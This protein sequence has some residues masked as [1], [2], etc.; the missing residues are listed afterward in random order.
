[1]ILAVSN[2]NTSNSKLRAVNSKN[3]YMSRTNNYSQ[4][5]DT[6]IKSQNKSK[7]SFGNL[8]GAGWYGTQADRDALNYK[9]QLTPEQVKENM[10]KA[11]TRQ[12]G[13]LTSYSQLSEE[14]QHV[15][16]AFK[17]MISIKNEFGRVASSEFKEMAKVSPK[18]SKIPIVGI[19][20]QITSIFSG[21]FGD[22]LYE[23]YD[24]LSDDMIEIIGRYWNN[25]VNP[26]CSDYWS[27][28]NSMLENL[29]GI[30]SGLKSRLDASIRKGHSQIS[31]NNEA[32][33]KSI[34]ALQAK[35]HPTYNNICEKQAGKQFLRLCIKGVTL[36]IGGFGF[37]EILAGPLAD[38]LGD[39]ATGSIAEA[40]L[41]S[42]VDELVTQGLDS[43]GNT[44]KEISHGKS[45]K[46]LQLSEKSL[47]NV[48]RKIR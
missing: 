42:G 18:G 37:E 29:Y 27:A 17:S 36:G 33:R 28:S 11:R 7:I 19:V 44:A 41:N 8:H 38:L 30:D 35:L 45:S 5:A 16:Q 9:V 26:I 3:R 40:L 14:A 24:R 23:F 43:I 13:I 4:S 31:D 2:L 32:I 25:G 22:R 10:R 20:P 12:A 21:S 34:N 1:M 6:F 46:V 15:G 47:V 39:A 48:L